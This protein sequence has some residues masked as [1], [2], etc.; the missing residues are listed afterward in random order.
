MEVHNSGPWE[1]TALACSQRRLSELTG[2][3]VRTCRTSTFDSPALIESKEVGVTS[4]DSKVS[5]SV[6]LITMSNLAPLACE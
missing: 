5:C 4:A 1:V 3:S 6:V 2:Y